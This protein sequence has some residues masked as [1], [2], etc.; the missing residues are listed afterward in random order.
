M[1]QSA[2]STVSEPIIKYEYIKTPQASSIKSLNNY[3]YQSQI[4]QQSNRQ[5]ENLNL[6]LETKM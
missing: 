3:N 4:S 2:I 1:K 5:L 6:V